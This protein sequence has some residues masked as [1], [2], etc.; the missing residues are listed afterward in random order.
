MAKVKDIV[1]EINNLK[2]WGIIKTIQ[3]KR[4]GIFFEKK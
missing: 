4:Y 3:E 2:K 1:E